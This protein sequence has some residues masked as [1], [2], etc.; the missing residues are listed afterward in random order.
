QLAG[1]E[2][3]V[4]RGPF[5]GAW[6]GSPAARR[7]ARARLSRVSSSATSERARRTARALTPRA[8]CEYHRAMPQPADVVQ[9]VPPRRLV[10]GMQ[11]PCPAPRTILAAPWEESARADELR[12]I[13]QVCDRSGFF[14]VAVCDHVCVPRE[15]AAAMR[16]TWYDTVATL[17]FLAAA[18][19]R[20]RLLSHVYVLPYRH[21]LQT[22]KAFATLDALSG[23]RVILGVG[24]GHLE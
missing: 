11:L 14:Y 2:R 22:A 4:H 9:I 15:R 12:R 21:P 20:V 23:G 5:G 10:S 1:G 8:S 24:A 16:T 7:V 17:G 18:T 3:E 6:G 19:T 13:A